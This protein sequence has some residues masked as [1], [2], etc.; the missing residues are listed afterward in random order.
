[1]VSDFEAVS[2]QQ[3][4]PMRFYATYPFEIDSK[5]RVQMP[6]KWRPPVIQD[7]GRRM[8]AI[9]VEFM[10]TLTR[11]RGDSCA[12]ITAMPA[13]VFEAYAQKVDGLPLLDPAAERLR[14]FLGSRSE[15]V[16][17]DSAGRITLPKW[18]ADKVGIEQ[19]TGADQNS[20]TV[21]LR[22]EVDRFSIWSK[23]K[24]DADEFENQKEDDQELE[25]QI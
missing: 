17:M 14:R 23:Q 10:L 16:T 4:K 11:V 25:N 13:E 7:G 6:S 9:E 21:V 19:K 1:M 5:R 3:T 22:G 2:D 8:A 15:P 12:C 20:T 18:M 24:F